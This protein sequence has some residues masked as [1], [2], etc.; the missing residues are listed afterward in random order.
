M[1]N[2]DDSL[3]F[4]KK[5]LK[6][7]ITTNVYF[8]KILN[9]K[10]NNIPEEFRITENNNLEI[11]NYLK[12]NTK[13]DK[14]QIIEKIL[15]KIL[16]DVEHKIHNI[17]LAKKLEKRKEQDFEIQKQQ[18][19][20]NN[21]LTQILLGEIN[22]NIFGYN[23]NNTEE[24]KKYLETY[25]NNLYKYISDV[26]KNIKSLSMLSFNTKKIYMNSKT[27]NK[28]TYFRT[29]RNSFLTTNSTNDEIRYDNVETYI[30]DF[31]LKQENVYKNS[32]SKNRFFF[33]LYI[34]LK[35]TKFETQNFNTIYRN[36]KRNMILDILNNY[37]MINYN[38]YWDIYYKKIL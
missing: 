28:S 11:Q 27:S 20:D 18:I 2:D 33:F 22:T 14:K 9:I 19:F 37:F 7:D 23:I 13:I 5:A 21:Y 30:H 10:T 34:Y 17:L 3:F 15:E 16:D 4:L 26:D 31:F 29:T 8:D 38:K 24:L 1:D 35:E 32:K 36:I 25:N 12:Q 6:D